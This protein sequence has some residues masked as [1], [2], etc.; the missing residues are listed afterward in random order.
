MQDFWCSVQS[1]ASW[2]RGGDFWNAGFDA[3]VCSDDDHST[4]GKG[5]HNLVMKDL[6]HEVPNCHFGAYSD[7]YGSYE[8]HQFGDG[9][10]QTEIDAGKECSGSHNSR[11]EDLEDVSSSHPFMQS[12]PLSLRKDGGRVNMGPSWSS[13]ANKFAE[14][15]EKSTGFGWSWQCC[16]EGNSDLQERCLDQRIVNGNEKLEKEL[17][18]VS[19][20]KE[21]DLFCHFEDTRAHAVIHQDDWQVCCRSLWHE[22][23]QIAQFKQ[24]QA[25]LDAYDQQSHAADVSSVTDNQNLIQCGYSRDRN[26][27]LEHEDESAGTGVLQ[28]L[29][30]TDDNARAEFADTWFLDQDRFPLCI[31]PRKL[32]L[33]NMHW[34]SNAFLV[35]SCKTLWNDLDDGSVISLYV[36]TEAPNRLPAIRFHIVIIQGEQL[37]MD[38]TLLHSVVSPMFYRLRAVLFPLGCTVNEFF[39]R[40]QV[41]APCNR[42]DRS[43][44][45]SHTEHG[46]TTFWNNDEPFHG[47]NSGFVEG[48]VR[49][50][51]L[52]DSDEDRSD[53]GNEEGSTDCPS[54]SEDD[55]EDASFMQGSTQP[56]MFQFDDENAYPWMNQGLADPEDEVLIPDEFD[57]PPGQVHL[58]EGHWDHLQ[59][60]LDHMNGD[61][62]SQ[63]SKWIAVT[64]GLSIF[65]LGRRDVEF[66]RDSMAS[67]IQ[68]ITEAWNDHLI[69]GDITVYT[70]HPQPTNIIGNGAIALLVVMT[71]P[72]DLEDGMRNVLVIE[73]AVE[74][75][76]ARPEPY[77]AKIVN[78]ITDREVLFHLDLHHHC[79][80]FALRPFYVR[81]GMSMMVHAQR[82]D[83]DHGTLCKTWIGH[84]FSQV[85]EAELYITEAETFFLQVQSFVELRG[86]GANIVCRV[87]GISPDNRPMGHRDIIVPA[88]WIY[89]LEW[90]HQMQRLWPFQDENI[91]LHFVV[92][93]TAD[94]R[95]EPNVVF[96]FIANWGID[97]D[98][99]ILVNQQLVSVDAMQ[100]DPGGSDEF[101]AICIPAGEIGVNI[102]GALH[103]PPFWFNYARSQHTRPHLMVN[104][105]RVI[106]IHGNWRAGDILRARFLVWQRHHILQIL[107]GVAQEE[108]DNALEYTS[109]LQTKM[110]NRM[111]SCANND[112]VY[113]SFTEVCSHLQ[114]V[115][116]QARTN[117]GDV[118]NDFSH[119]REAVCGQQHG[120]GD[121]A[122]PTWCEG[123][124]A[125]SDEQVST[126]NI[127]VAALCLPGWR[128][129][130]IDVSTVPNMHPH[131]V[132]ASRLTMQ[133]TAAIGTFHIYTDGSFD[134]KRGKAAWAFTIVCAHT[135]LVH[136][137]FTRVGFAGG[138]VDD[139]VGP[140]T[141]SAHDAEATCSHC[142]SMR[143]YP[144]SA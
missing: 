135:N 76:G 52:E 113:D 7:G 128:G 80:P 38:W 40:A 29:R 79:P 57:N 12:F 101:W 102:V 47:T 58:A 139:G 129:I 60:E 33:E 121:N 140:V 10:S 70:V 133:D 61:D 126:L 84:T 94:M 41:E 72:E 4:Y 59:E 25:V 99:P 14:Q 130:N 123:P 100:N 15:F 11:G 62:C 67:L 87:H 122:D 37:N 1:Q 22:H 28:G 124:E 71:T 83:L 137:L 141:I 85:A 30:I 107:I 2:V 26:V 117:D 56:T 68:A 73:E 114:K 96:H 86:T 46:R 111:S 49:I 13:R 92:H 36:V 118:S 66:Q 81:M 8:P 34:T 35:R 27:Y 19:F 136:T 115:D 31:K 144:V 18:K 132:L 106:E 65:D 44:F 63:E 45:L 103:G 53:S 104:G 64:Y 17:R 143:V 131:A 82:Y 6:F 54:A 138:L 109:F 125:V 95:E 24:F 98:V 32:R 39:Y 43:C 112:W 5:L 48:G 134:K 120:G 77:G 16:E 119:D 3:K 97:A 116:E 88:D 51:H 69:F 74:E 50:L 75:V 105:Q 9:A 142:G 89:D 78:E 55:L 110:K 23:G 20:A 90:I 21:V 93:A 42:F 108:H 91:L 127:A